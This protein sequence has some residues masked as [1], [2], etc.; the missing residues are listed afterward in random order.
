MFDPDFLDDAGS[1]FSLKRRKKTKNNNNPV[2][3]EQGLPA[4]PC[5][6]CYSTAAAV[7]AAR[8]VV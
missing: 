8:E 7:R 1:I 2:P 6:I 3:L 4:F 5:E